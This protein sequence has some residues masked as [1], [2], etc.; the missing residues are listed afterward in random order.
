MEQFAA[1]RKQNSPTP[2]GEKAE[3][4]DAHEAAG[5]YVHQKTADE[6]LG[7]NGHFSLSVAMSIISPAES[8]VPAIEGE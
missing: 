2:I 8:N 6:L 1:E 4:S 3:V 5:Q 7:G